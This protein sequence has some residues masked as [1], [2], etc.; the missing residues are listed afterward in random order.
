MWANPG[1]YFRRF[2][3]RRCYVPVR[4]E[5]KEPGAASVVIGLDATVYLPYNG[6]AILL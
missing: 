6:T 2:E 3:E 1:T 4:F 5:T